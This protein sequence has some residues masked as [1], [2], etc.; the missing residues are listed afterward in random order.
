MRI[1]VLALLI[2]F[3]LL[4]RPDPENVSIDVQRLLADVSSKPLGINTDF[5]VDDDANRSPQR[6]LDQGLSQ[7]GVKYLRYPGGEKSDGYLWSVPPY[8]RSQ[9]TLARWA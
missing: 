6:T 5:F 1:F 3:P 7:M 2:S 9:P 4:T 8:D